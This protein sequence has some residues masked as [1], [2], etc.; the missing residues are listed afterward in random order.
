MQC[1]ELLSTPS[2]ESG[3]VTLSS[4]MIDAISEQ[5]SSSRISLQVAIS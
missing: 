4:W 3:P 2:N 5:S 1:G